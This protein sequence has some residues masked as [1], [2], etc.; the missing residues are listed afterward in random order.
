MFSILLITGLNKGG[1]NIK[2]AFAISSFVAL[3]LLLHFNSL[4]VVVG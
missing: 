1:Q 3:K 4:E 2:I